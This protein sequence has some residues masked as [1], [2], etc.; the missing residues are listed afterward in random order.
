MLYALLEVGQVC[1]CD[2]A[3]TV[4]VP[5]TTVSNALRLCARPALFATA[6]RA[7]DLLQP[8]RRP[9]P[10]DVANRSPRCSRLTVQPQQRPSHHRGG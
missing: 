2:L 8:G 7:D 3:A 1:V 5:E 10:P 4:D 9:R 6:G